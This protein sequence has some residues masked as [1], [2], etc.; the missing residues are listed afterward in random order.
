[1]FFLFNSF[2]RLKLH[3]HID[4]DVVVRLLEFVS[5]TQSL[6]G[7]VLKLLVCC[8]S[9]CANEATGSG[10]HAHESREWLYCL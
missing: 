3:D 7:W 6:K 9:L 2:F 1:M 8:V 10:Q 5:P 4:V